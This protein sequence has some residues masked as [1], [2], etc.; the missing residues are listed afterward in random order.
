MYLCP[1]K[2]KR[3][4]NIDPETLI[5][6]LPAPRELKPF[7]NSLCSVFKGHVGQVRAITV[8][9]DG[10]YLASGGELEAENNGFLLFFNI[11]IE[12]YFKF[13]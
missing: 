7:P 9:P 13:L 3:R 10:Q 11:N 8:S 4:L 5:P 12:N 6:R 2:M 1:R